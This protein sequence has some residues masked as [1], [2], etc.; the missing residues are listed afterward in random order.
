MPFAEYWNGSPELLSAYI[1]A[2]RKQREVEKEEKAITLD[3]LAYAHG[4]YM[5]NAIGTAFSGKNQIKEP[6]RFFRKPESKEE[7]QARITRE[8]KEGFKK[9]EMLKFA[10]EEGIEIKGEAR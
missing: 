6:I 7:L 1:T 5:M 3:L 4:I 8:I 2:F 9:S 10:R